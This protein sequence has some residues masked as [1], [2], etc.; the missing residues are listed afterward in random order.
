MGA[1]AEDRYRIPAPARNPT[2]VAEARSSD[3][4]RR[5][6]RKRAAAFV[7]HTRERWK[8][9]RERKKLAW[10]K[11]RQQLAQRPDCPPVRVCQS[12]GE[13]WYAAPRILS[14]AH[15][16]LAGGREDQLLPHLPPVPR[17]A[18]AERRSPFGNRRPRVGLAPKLKSCGD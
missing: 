8:Q 17:R 2:L 3:D 12:C 11:L 5:Q 13:Q 9:W 6:Q 14:R 16:P 10:E 4:Y 15:A 1:R 18:A 7:A